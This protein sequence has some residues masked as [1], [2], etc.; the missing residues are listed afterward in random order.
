[1]QTE[2]N[3]EA[4]STTSQLEW[5]YPIPVEVSADAPRWGARAIYTETHAE[6]HTTR[7]AL[8]KRPPDAFAIELLWDRQGMAGGTEASRKTLATWL[9]K[10]GL[11]ALR[12]EC[13]KL[14]VCPD[15]DTVINLELDGYAMVASPNASY[16]YLYISAWRVAS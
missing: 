5:G 10:T 9:D 1:M 4:T 6:R 16:G 12:K 2:E 11:P 13:S 8:M 14:Y 3:P 7:G 15:H